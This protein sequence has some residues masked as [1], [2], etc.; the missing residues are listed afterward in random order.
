METR[1]KLARQLISERGIQEVRPTD[2]FTPVVLVLGTLLGPLGWAAGLAMLWRSGLWSRAEKWA[3]TFVFPELVAAY[4]ATRGG[5]DS[6]ACLPHV[7]VS[8]TCQ[9]ASMI[10]IEVVAL[11]AAAVTIFRLSRTLRRERDFD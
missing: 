5:E 11:V 4:L 2:R 1:R 6:T 8:L 10:L 9:P 7:G 3:G